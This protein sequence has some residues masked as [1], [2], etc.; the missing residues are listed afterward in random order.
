MNEQTHA[1]IGSLLTGYQ[2]VYHEYGKRPSW[3]KDLM[4][5][6]GEIQVL[7]EKYMPKNTTEENKYGMEL[8]DSK[9]FSQHYELK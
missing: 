8:F 4:N 5:Y 6:R 3:L 2:L 9:Y 1:L 7:L